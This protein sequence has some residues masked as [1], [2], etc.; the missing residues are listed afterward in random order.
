MSISYE[1][2]KVINGP[3][4]LVAIVSSM[5]APWNDEVA[6][7]IADTIELVDENVYSAEWSDDTKIVCTVTQ[8]AGQYVMLTT[9][10]ER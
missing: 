9:F 1:S 7:R 2:V 8:L 5:T 4:N 10:L 6:A 3:A